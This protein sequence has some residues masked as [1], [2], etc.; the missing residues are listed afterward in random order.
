MWNPPEPADRADN[1]G[2]IFRPTD[3]FDGDA[4]SLIRYATGIAPRDLI[5]WDAAEAHN[6]DEIPY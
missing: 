3:P 2:T 5:E 6:E 1:I 4:N